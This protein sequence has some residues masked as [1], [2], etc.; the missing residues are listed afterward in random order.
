MFGRSSTD[1]SWTSFCT[2]HFSY[3]VHDEKLARDA[4]SLSQIPQLKEIYLDRHAGC[5]RGRTRRSD[6]SNVARSR[7]VGRVWEETIVGRDRS[8]ACACNVTNIFC[9]LQRLQVLPLLEDTET[10]L[11]EFGHCSEALAW[12]YQASWCAK[13]EAKSITKQ[14]WFSSF[15]GCR[16]QRIIYVPQSQN[17][18]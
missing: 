13:H 6:Q 11:N 12:P 3:S 2:V 17:Y 1:E 16:L 15:L 7:T 18:K 5:F 4:D 9:R 8:D 14:I 10:S